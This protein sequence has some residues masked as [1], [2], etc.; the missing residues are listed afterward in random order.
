MVRMEYIGYTQDRQTWGI[1]I[2]VGVI[3]L[4]DQKKK[5]KKKREKKKEEKKIGEG[6]KEIKGNSK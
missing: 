4:N 1:I 3:K 6:P 5:K 2:G